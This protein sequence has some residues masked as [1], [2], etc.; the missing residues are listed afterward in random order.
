MD[1]KTLVDYLSRTEKFRWNA[2]KAMDGWRAPIND[3]ERK[4]IEAMED[5]R[6]Y[7]QLIHPSLVSYDEL[8]KKD[9]HKDEAIVQIVR[10]VIGKT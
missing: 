1:E 2:E 10:E 8:T 3:K 4:Q 6:N 9:Q 5:G 7:D